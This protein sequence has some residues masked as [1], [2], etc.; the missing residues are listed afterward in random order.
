MNLKSVGN[1]NTAG[2]GPSSNAKNALKIDVRRYSVVNYPQRFVTFQ[3]VN[4]FSAIGNTKFLDL[5]SC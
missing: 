2:E 5:L 3:I 4:N 1:T